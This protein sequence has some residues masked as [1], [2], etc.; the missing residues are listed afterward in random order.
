[1]MVHLFLETRL[2]G[3]GEGLGLVKENCKLQRVLGQKL[4]FS[5]L[6]I[7]RATRQ[8]VSKLFYLLSS[9]E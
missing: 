4:L 8:L 6:F 7:R 5:V 1:M 2:L 3:T 9:V